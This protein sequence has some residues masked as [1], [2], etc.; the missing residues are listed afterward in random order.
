MKRSVCSL[1]LIVTIF[2]T[3]S[4]STAREPAKLSAV[5]TGAP[6]VRLQGTPAQLGAE[7]GRQ[8]AAQI[9][10]LHEQFLQQWLR[11]DVQRAMALAAAQGFEPLLRP[12]HKE[13]LHSL[14]AAAGVDEGQMLLSNCFLDVG[15]MVTCSTLTL[16]AL[17]SSD[18]VARFARNLDFPSFNIADKHSVV[19]V[20][21]PS[22][23][24]HGFVHVGWPGLIG[25]LTGM[26]EHGLTIASMEV[27]R[28][29]RPPTAMPYTLLYRTIL[30]R[31][32]T[33]D[34]ALALLET[35]PKQTANNLMIMDAA[36]QRALAEIYPD[37]VFVRRNDSGSLISTNHRRELIDPTRYPEQSCPRYARLAQ[38][39]SEPGRTFGVVDLQKL[40]AEVAQGD[41]T[42]QSMVF[43]PGNRVMYM[44]TGK[45]APQRQWE[46]IDIGEL[47]K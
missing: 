41:M 7:H 42:L 34:E 13:E 25:V 6:T 29:R 23:G 14:A 45:N 47:L 46:R 40:L 35:T 4:C 11:S 8:L 21:K 36:G 39:T 17:Q 31:C 12:E 2:V 38:A 18:G 26:N 32:R 30:E 33:V 20:V 1:G 24:R 37:R 15:G 43:E 9:K 10:P 3:F 16:P 27:T 22:D 28:D 5:R 44:A 19:F